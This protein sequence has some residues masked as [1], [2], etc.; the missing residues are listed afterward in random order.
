MRQTIAGAALLG[1]VLG[2]QPSLLAQGPATAVVDIGDVRL[3][4]VT[5]GIGDPVILLPGTGYSSSAFGLLGPEL[6]FR[7]GTCLHKLCLP[8]PFRYSEDLD[9]VR[10][11]HGGGPRPSTV[12]L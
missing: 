11:T 5:W 4:T 8:Q 1:A 6:A 2:Q 10:T 3:E 12:T 9:Y 7:G